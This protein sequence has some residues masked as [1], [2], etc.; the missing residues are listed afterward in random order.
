MLTMCLM[1]LVSDLVKGHVDL[2]TQAIETGIAGMDIL[3]QQ[4]NGILGSLIRM[5]R[6][7]EIQEPIAVLIRLVETRQ[8]QLAALVQWYL[9]RLYLCYQ[10]CLLHCSLP[11]RQ[12]VS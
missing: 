5:H 10:G 6:L 1:T 12:R 7:D 3:L 4:T 11:F 2:P 9:R 8:H